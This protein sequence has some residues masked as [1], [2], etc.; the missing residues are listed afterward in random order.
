MDRWD[1]VLLLFCGPD[2]IWVTPGGGVEAG[3]TPAEAAARE[4]WEETGLRVQPPDLLGPVAYA[5]DGGRARDDFFYLRVGEHDVDDESHDEFDRS[6]WWTLQ[7]LRE[8][9]DFVVPFGMADLLASI[10]AGH[11]GAQPAALPWR[12]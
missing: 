9:T 11:V 2:G 10:A 6:R 7:E 8:T 3:E 12:Q 1:R 5:E 4:L